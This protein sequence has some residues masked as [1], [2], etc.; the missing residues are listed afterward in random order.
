M[1]DFSAA[2]PLQLVGRVNL[3]DSGS[4]LRGTSA[5]SDPMFVK[6]AMSAEAKKQNPAG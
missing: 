1:G 5:S 6:I 4:A 2:P 3:P